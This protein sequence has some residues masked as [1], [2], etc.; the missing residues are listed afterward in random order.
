MVKNPPAYQ[1]IQDQ[2]L[3]WKDPLEKEMATR[4]SILAW[5][6]PWTEESG[7][8]RS[9]WGRKEWDMPEYT[10]YWLSLHK[11]TFHSLSAEDSAPARQRGMWTVSP[12]VR[13]PSK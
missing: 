6:T 9:P 11:P 8:L 5:E 10:H 3:S 7:R 1:E 4:S 12:A 2:S 13:V